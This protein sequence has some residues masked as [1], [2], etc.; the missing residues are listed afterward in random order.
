[1]MRPWNPEGKVWAS[2]EPCLSPH[3]TNQVPHGTGA[4]LVVGRRP[5]HHVDLRE[6]QV[7]QFVSNI[8]KR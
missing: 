6:V 7:Y 3:P 1:M 5:Q 4:A 2:W 8:I